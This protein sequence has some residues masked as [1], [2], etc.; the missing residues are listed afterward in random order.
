M[1]PIE[2]QRAIIDRRELI[3]RIDE[4]AGD[5]EATPGQARARILA[6]LKDSLAAGRAEIRRRFEAG[7]QGSEVLAANTLLMDQIIR[8]LYD[9]AFERAYPLANPTSGERQAI[10]AVGGYGRGELAPYSDLDLLFLLTYKPTPHTEQVVEYMLY[11][12]WDLGLKVGHATRSVDECIRMA[13]KDLTIRTALLEARYLWGDTALF[14]DLRRRFLDDISTGSGIEFVEAKLA[15]RDARHQRM[16]DS[17]YVL[18]P[19]IKEGKGGLRDLQTLYWIAKYLY[20]VDDAR[21]LVSRNVFS[22]KEAARFGKAHEFLVTVRCH[23]HF[24]SGRVE[25]RLAFD[26]Q[27]KIGDRMGYSGHAG[28]SGV[29]RFMKYYFLIAKDVGDLTRIFCAALEAEHRRKPR[30][31]LA[32]LTGR[33]REVEGFLVEGGWL[34]IK[35]ERAFSDDP[36]N[37]IRLFHTAQAHDFDVHPQAL[38]RITRDIKRVNGKL[39]ADAEANRLFLEILTSPKE[40][41]VAL[42]RMNEAG[43]LGRFIPDFGRVMAQMQYD[44]YHV[45]TVDEHTIRA[46]G[47][48]HGIEA[49][50]LKKDH[51]LSS[52]I[53]S[54]VI[55]RRVLYLAVF[56][57]DIAK[58]RGGSHSELGAEVARKLAPRL[59]L[60]AEETETVSWL[61]LH[62]L[63]MSDTA[64]KRD[65]DD[66]T[67]VNAFADLVQSPERLRLLLV[68][69]VADMRATG[70]NVFNGWKATLLRELYYR[71]EE[72]MSGSPAGERIAERVEAARAALGENLDGWSEAERDAHFALGYPPYWLS[73]D[74]ATHVRHAALVREAE[75]EDKPLA[76]DTRVDAARAIT[77]IT[78]YTPDHPG[79]FSQ[80]AGAMALSGAN[81]VDAK[82]FTMTNGKA[83][84]IFWVQDSESGAFDRP[85][86]LTRLT[87]QIEKSLSGQLR[88]RGELAGR[89]TLPKRARVFQ[90]APRVL[91]DNKASATH[92]LI[93]VNGRDRPGL[94]YEVTRAL[95]ELGLQIASAKISTYGERVVDVFYVKDVFGMK[96]EREQKL[97]QIRER[98]LEALAPAQ[99][100][101]A[102]SAAAERAKTAAEAPAE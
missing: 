76:I 24:L 83:L 72:A 46:I 41:E 47:I 1:Q 9:F 74:D 92:T 11:M 12:L 93:E 75:R 3:Q 5:R 63:A 39:R 86:R 34:N 19:N 95:T 8:V 40:P 17:R 94:L 69:T 29:E 59:G 73:L 32:R 35:D 28:L 71:A 85:E 43:V 2:N 20:R 102:E 61:V 78:V 82:I 88:P 44:M 38:R 101:G 15:E 50:K 58:G 21:D 67:T 42:K 65:I 62:H 77:E 45:Y 30:L 23:L 36:V 57:H 60:D 90:V 70:P 97:E 64:Q 51:P 48:L 7:G 91:I 79:L 26:L 80:I 10:V 22:A 66:P 98:V 13:G 89:E 87:G 31:S 81:I 96:I 25:E 18:E 52:E 55:S 84:D 100:E 33:R 54:K 16:G 56:L 14:A 99:E 49:G 27:P 4:I 68:L 37:F 53:V 6:C